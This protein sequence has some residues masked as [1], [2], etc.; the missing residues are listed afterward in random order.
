MKSHTL[1]EVIILFGKV[2]WGSIQEQGHGDSCGASLD[3]ATYQQRSQHQGDN[4]SD[5]L[6]GL[7]PCSLDVD[8]LQR[9]Y[10]DI[11]QDGQYR[12]PE[13][14]G[15]VK[16]HARPQNHRP[17]ETL[18]SCSTVVVLL[19]DSVCVCVCVFLCVMER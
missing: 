6:Q 11:L 13:S 18:T 15:R 4:Q 7:S 16:L 10:G 12:N 9:P 14:T 8:N 19:C 3:F 1:I 2:L 17:F 5:R